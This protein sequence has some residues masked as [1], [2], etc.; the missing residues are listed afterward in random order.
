MLNANA[1]YEV[2]KN[3]N[4]GISNGGWNGSAYAS[5]DQQLPLKVR[6]GVRGGFYKMGASGLYLRGD[7]YN[8]WYGISLHRSFLKEDRLSVNMYANNPIGWHHTKWRQRTVNAGYDQLSESVYR[9]YSFGVS[10]SY[11]FGSFYAQVKKT[12]KTINNDD[13]EGIK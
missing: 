8:P 9:S 3:G 7:S 1:R 13:L 5:V 2:M 10:V 6:L 4:L 11:R 12:A